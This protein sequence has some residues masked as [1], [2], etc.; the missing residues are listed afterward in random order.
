MRLLDVAASQVVSE[1]AVGDVAFCRAALGT[2]PTTTGAV[3]AV[4]DPSHLSDCLV[5]PLDDARQVL[6]RLHTASETGTRCSTWNSWGCALSRGS[7]TA[8]SLQ[9]C[10]WPSRFCRHRPTSW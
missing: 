6:S 3:C 9:A 5:R 1:F 2:L 4:P 10:A 8:E 7:L